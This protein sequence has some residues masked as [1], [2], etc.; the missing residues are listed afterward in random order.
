VPVSLTVKNLGTDTAS[1]SWQDAIY[2]ST[3]ST[4]DSTAHFLTSFYQS[5]F[6]NPGFEIPSTL[7]GGASYTLSTNVS[8]PS[9]GGGTFY[10]CFRTNINAGLSYDEQDETNLTNNIAAQPITL[11]P[12]ATPTVD[13]SIASGS[14][15]PATVEEGNGATVNL[16]WTVTNN[17]TTSASGFWQD[18]AF[19][20]NDAN[21]SNNFSNRLTSSPGPNGLGAGS[22]YTVSQSVKVPAATTGQ[23]DIVLATNIFGGVIESQYTN[24][25]VF[26][27]IT[28]TA[29]DV[30]L[31]VTGATVPV[32]QAVEGG[33]FE[34]S[35]TVKNTGSEAAGAGW[36]DAVY[37]SDAPSLNSDN[38]VQVAA[39][40]GHDQAGLA[41]GAS[42]TDTERISVPATATGL[43]YLLFVTNSTRT[44]SETNANDNVFAAPITL[45]APD[46][47]TTSF[48][49]P[50]T[51]TVDQPFTFSWGVRNQGAV[52]APAS[53][54]DAV[55]LWNSPVYSGS[56]PLDPYG[57][58]R[59]ATKTESAHAGL[60]PGA[61]YSD[62]MQ[63]T[64]SSSDFLSIYNKLPATSPLYLLFV[65]D[66]GNTQPQSD[67]PS[68]GS[69]PDANDFYAAPI[70]LQSPDLKVT[71]ATAPSS[72]IEGAPIN[73]TWTVQNAGP[74]PAFGSWYDA[75][76]A[77]SSQTLDSTATPVA[78]FPESHSG[79]SELHREP[80]GHDPTDGGGQPLLAIRDQFCSTVFLQRLAT[81][82]RR[83]RRRAR[84]Q[85]RPGEG[86]F[87][88]GP[89]LATH[90]GN[91]VGRLGRRG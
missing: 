8:L 48:V 60:L 51:F 71:A 36:T 13:L 53:W 65:A 58:I 19:L 82:K 67:N 33:P 5:A 72:A 77:S 12:A 41:A 70:Q 6:A 66:E 37:V 42:Y 62:Q 91:L 81:R 54:S 2:I 55:Y 46:L 23:H 88:Y 16:Q 87:D 15:L 76:Y 59:L 29:P 11:S 80:A 49:S 34:V 47:A 78:D 14:T 20:E 3:N 73:V 84:C 18:G 9:V 83:W 10:L 52:S 57:P 24:N 1:G 86:D 26:L 64:I 61:G 63:V 4:F 38:V 39:F 7:A 90:G 45:K 17:G 32:S 30:N 56:T 69:N 79:G 22:N 74:V 40:A 25:I 44:Q 50:A 85:R 35:W 21:L 28:L 31:T 43:R 27:P 68:G 75:V 89:R